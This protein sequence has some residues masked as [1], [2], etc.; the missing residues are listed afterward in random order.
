MSSILPLPPLTIHIL[1]YSD[2]LCALLKKAHRTGFIAILLI[3]LLASAMIYG[4]FHMVC[5][6]NRTLSFHKGLISYGLQIQK[7]TT[8]AHQVPTVCTTLMIATDVA[9]TGAEGRQSPGGLDTHVI[10]EI[11]G[12]V[13]TGD[14]FMKRD[15]TEIQ[16]THT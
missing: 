1:N 8:P 10:T 7:L 13:Y 3:G 12:N 2:A 14:F 15:S 6:P 16:F 11:G 4:G 9:P 5:L